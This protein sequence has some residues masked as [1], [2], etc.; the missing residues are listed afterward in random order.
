MLINKKNYSSNQLKEALIASQ[1]YQDK[2]IISLIINKVDIN[3]KWINENI[4]DNS[5]QKV[6][7]SYIKIT[8]F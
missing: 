8:N 2:W 4:K 3:E 7:K 6:I 5:Y 1:Y